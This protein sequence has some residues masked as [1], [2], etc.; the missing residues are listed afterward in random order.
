MKFP[1]IFVQRKIKKIVKINFSSMFGRGINCKSLRIILKLGVKV[2]G[3]DVSVLVF[4]FRF[5]SVFPYMCQSRYYNFLFS[6]I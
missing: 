5:E 6:Y 2:N 1:L 4:Q 3:I